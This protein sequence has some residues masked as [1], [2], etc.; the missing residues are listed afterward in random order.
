M[1]F[2]YARIS[3]HKE[4]QKTDRQ[5]LLLREYATANGF[6]IDETV[7]EIMSGKDIDRPKY[8]ALKAKMRHGDILIISD[9]DRLGRNA[10]QVIME[11]KKLKADGIKVVALDTP[12]LNA[13][14][15]IQDDSM[16]A[17][18]TDIL[19]TLKAHLAQQEREKLIDRV[20]A[21]LAVAREK[22]HKLGRP[23]KQ[24][25]TDVIKMYQRVQNGELTKIEASKLLGITRQHFDRLIKQA[26]AGRN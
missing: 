16:Y 21:G 17:M 25:G 19:I 13:W 7:E 18:I 26:E 1:I 22:G 24:V 14:D 8:S 3:T 23:P 15:S 11:F 9:I 12:Y 20:N 6:T 4:T 2:A 10:D 5:L